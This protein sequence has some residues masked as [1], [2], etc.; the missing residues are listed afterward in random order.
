[1]ASSIDYN[2]NNWYLPLVGYRNSIYLFV[3]WWSLLI[4][5]KRNSLFRIYYKDRITKSEGG[6]FGNAYLIDWNS[7]LKQTIDH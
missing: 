3:E 6:I 2:K 5:K 1:M 7:I 4:E